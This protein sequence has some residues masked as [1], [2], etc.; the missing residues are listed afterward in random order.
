[1]EP[2]NKKRESRQEPMPLTVQ[3]FRRRKMCSLGPGHEFISLRPPKIVGFTKGF[4]MVRWCRVKENL[5]T[6][7]RPIIVRSFLLLNCK[8][9]S[10]G[11]AS[12]GGFVRKA[13]YP[14]NPHTTK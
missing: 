2:L 13:N 8:S 1:M 6:Q 12:G 11:P 7:N 9:P 14:G 3:S 10:V 4:R 5:N